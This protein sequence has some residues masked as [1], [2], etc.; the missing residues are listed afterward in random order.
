MASQPESPGTP[1]TFKIPDLV[2]TRYGEWLADGEEITHERTKSVLFRSIHRDPVTQELRIQVGKEKLPFRAEDTAYFIV[3][4]RGNPEAG[5]EVK[6]SE[7]EWTPLNLESLRYSEANGDSRLVCSLI[8]HSSQA[9]EAA[10]FLYA[11]YHALLLH[12]QEHAEGD[13]THFILRTASHQILLHS[14]SP[15][16]RK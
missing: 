4:L 1:P 5:F 6:T 8:T 10:R 12:A 3:A 2:L 9:V 15:N 13:Q 11:P 14:V 16:T 7:G